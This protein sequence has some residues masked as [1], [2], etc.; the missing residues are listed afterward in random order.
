MVPLDLVKLKPLLERTGGRPEV[1]IGLIDGPVAT[2]HAG[3]TASNVRLVGKDGAGTCS[4]TESVACQHGTF[5]AGILVGKRGSGAPAICPDCTMLVRP[6]FSEEHATDDS[7]PSATAEEL[8]AA[9]VDCVD[10]GVQVLNVS[11]GLATPTTHDDRAVGAALDHAARRGVIVIAA[12]GNQGTLGGTAITRHPWVIPVA[13]YDQTGKPMAYSNLG[14]SI[15]RRGLGAPG[16]QITSF[17]AKGGYITLS[18]TSVAAPFVAGAAALLWSEFPKAPASTIKFAI[19][20][21]MARRNTVTPPLLDAWAS[22]QSL[23]A[24]SSGRSSL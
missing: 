13:A 3:L 10:A 17:S 12:A 6:I 22:F 9:I 24:T 19:C 18:G 20:Q 7:M 14:G 23:M 1:R 4:R 15:G 21:P 16:E 8:A 11:A 5:V 2:S